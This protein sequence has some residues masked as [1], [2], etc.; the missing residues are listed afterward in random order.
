VE[1]I[2]KKKKTIATSKPDVHQGYALPYYAGGMKTFQKL[3]QKTVFSG[4]ITL[5]TLPLLHG[6]NPHDNYFLIIFNKCN[7]L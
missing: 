4:Q 3:L 6:G 2:K 5:H 1:E 7:L